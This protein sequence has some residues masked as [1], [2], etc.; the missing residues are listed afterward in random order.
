[1]SIAT[2]QD[3]L[4]LERAPQPGPE[5]TLSSSRST[6]GGAPLI[7]P[8][9]PSH[10]PLADLPLAV[11]PSPVAGHSTSMSLPPSP[12]QLPLASFPIFIPGNPQLYEH[13]YGRGNT[14]KI[15]IK[16]WTGANVPRRAKVLTAV[17]C[18]RRRRERRMQELGW[19]RGS[20]SRSR[21]RKTQTRT[22]RS[23]GLWCGYSRVSERGDRARGRE[24]GSVLTCRSTVIVE[25]GRDAT[26]WS[27]P[28]WE[29]AV[30]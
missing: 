15:K 16:G 21:V 4:V 22:G 14:T 2:A 23:S 18:A 26:L 6:G 13:D 7:C 8:S 10:L 5:S 9:A 11:A 12:I 19:H 29:E 24:G 17:V 20:S 1:M 25:S 3:L 30:C 27:P 28:Q